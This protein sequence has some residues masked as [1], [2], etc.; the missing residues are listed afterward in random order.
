[1]KTPMTRA[2]VLCALLA[3]VPLAAAGQFKSSLENRPGVSESILQP[4]TSDAW[5]GIFDPNRLSMRHTFSLSYGAFGGGRGMSLGMYTNSLFYRIADPLDVQVDVSLM[6]SPSSSYMGGPQKDFSGIY[7]TRAQLN[8]RPSQSTLVQ[9]NFQQ[10]PVSPWMM[11]SP[12]RSPF[13][14]FGLSRTPE[15]N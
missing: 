12:Y 1:M 10:Y 8:Y 14:D 3:L 4:G 15:D 11:G 7:I 5:L 2:V 9:I 13:H 6:Y